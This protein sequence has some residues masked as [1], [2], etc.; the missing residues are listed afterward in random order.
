M[1]AKNPVDMLEDDLNSRVD[2]WRKEADITYRDVIGA[3]EVVKAGLIQEMLENE[4]DDGE[5][6]GKKF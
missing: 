6:N 1:A 5:A 2:Y 3:L 4:D